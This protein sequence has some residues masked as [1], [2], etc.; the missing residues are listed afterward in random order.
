MTM[1]IPLLANPEQYAFE[2]NV[3]YRQS[4]LDRL[5]TTNTDIYK[6]SKYIS[7]DNFWKRLYHEDFGPRYEKPQKWITAYMEKRLRDM[8]E[9]LKPAD[10]NE[11]SVIR[12]MTLYCPHVNLLAIHNLQTPVKSSFNHIPL[13]LI[14]GN[15]T[16]LQ[17]IDFSV[18]VKDTVDDFVVSYSNLSDQDVVHLA[19]GLGMCDDLKRFRLAGTKLTPTMAAVLGR[20]IE[21]CTKLE[22]LT[23]EN[24]NLN[25][26]GVKYFLYGLATDSL[27]SIKEINLANNFICK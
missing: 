6:L 1:V 8:L 5:T 16:E 2:N 9:K 3:R 22:A 26:N 25:D 13:N 12:E 15:L 17:E 21:R 27:P 18:N 11:E 20:A 19:A 14:L 4:V 7:D 23:I 24:C 10:Y